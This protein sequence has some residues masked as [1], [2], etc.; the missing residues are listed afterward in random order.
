MTEIHSFDAGQRQEPVAVVLGSKEVARCVLEHS[1]DGIAL[2]DLALRCVYANPRF[3]QLA[4]LAPSQYLEKMPSELFRIVRAE[5]DLSQWGCGQKLGLPGGSSCIPTKTESE[6]LSSTSNWT[7]APVPLSAS[8]DSQE[9]IHNVSVKL[10]NQG[11]SDRDGN[12]GLR[13][14]GN[15]QVAVIQCPPATEHYLPRAVIYSSGRVS[16]MLD[17]D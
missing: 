15:Q 5:V 17:T 3:E 6:Q 10:T 11:G 14:H 8:W 16:S 4:G 1:P 9:L 7:S 13:L 12:G 2:Y